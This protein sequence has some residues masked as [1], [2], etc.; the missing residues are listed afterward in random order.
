MTSHVRVLN[1]N[2]FPITDRFDG[3]PFTFAPEKA[4]NVPLEIAAHFFGW[5]VDGDGSV[6]AEVGPDSAMHA[7][8]AHVC[9]RWGWNTYNQKRMPDGTLESIAECVER[10]ARMTAEWVTKLKLTAISYALREVVPTDE[11]ELAP[12]KA[13]VDEDAEAASKAASRR[14]MTVG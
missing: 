7:D 13:L 3:V 2:A 12:P 10:T 4:V 14:K 6:N 9:R 1:E 5:R 11:F 8:L